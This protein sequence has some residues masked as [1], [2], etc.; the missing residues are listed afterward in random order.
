MIDPIDSLTFSL[1][2]NK[3]AYALLLG[4]GVSRAA[5]I[6][7]GWEIVEN[8]I[9]R[10][11]KARGEDCEPDPANWYEKTIDEVPTYSGLLKV[12]ARSPLERQQLMRGYFEPTD[13]EREQGLKLPTK[14][15]RA[16]ATLVASGHVRVILT[17]N[18]D[19]LT[20]RALEEVGVVPTV[21]SSPDHI[22]GLPP[23]LQLT[24]LVLK[25]HGDYLD[26]RIK[27][28]PEELARYDKSL[29]VCW[30]GFLTNLDSSS[31]AGRRSGTL[32]FVQQSHDARATA[33]RPT[34]LTGDNSIPKP[35]ASLR[36]GGHRRSR[37][38]MPI[39]SSSP[40]R[41]AS[42]LLRSTTALIRYQW[43]WL[44]RL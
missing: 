32:L 29:I 39:P 3:G 24:C 19:R 44:W 26:S 31:V 5:G 17:T 4:S 9:R 38:L 37:S 40:W 8:L 2:A 34:G 25:L 7:T 6:P 10:L 28:T 12:L 13:T 15:H 23:L 22:Q 41:A 16:I 35:P 30:I 27:N 11:A 33:S 20:E 42:K 36:K 43:A 14:A 1:H 21:A 18:F